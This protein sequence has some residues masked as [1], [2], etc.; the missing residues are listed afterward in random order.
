ME[1]LIGY[2]VDLTDGWH[3]VCAVAEPIASTTKYVAT[4]YVDGILQ[5]QAKIYSAGGFNPPTLY[6]SPKPQQVFEQLLSNIA[7]VTIGRHAQP[8]AA[9][10]YFMGVID[11]VKVFERALTPSEIR[12]LIPDSDDDFMPD[13][14]EKANNLDYLNPADAFFDPDLD[15]L[16]NRQEWFLRTDPHFADAAKGFKDSDGDGLPDTWEVMVGLNHLDAS[17]AYAD[18]DFDGVLNIYEFGLDTDPF[19]SDSDDNSVSD[20]SEDH[21]RDL[22]PDAWELAHGLN[23]REKDDQVDG[24][25][26]D[27]VNLVEYQRSSDPNDYYDGALPIITRISPD[28]VD[29]DPGAFGA[30]PFSVTI[31]KED[32]SLL[33]NAPVKFKVMSGDAKVAADGKDDPQLLQEID[34]VT[35]EMGVVTAFISYPSAEGDASIVRAIASTKVESAILDVTATTLS[36][37]ATPTATPAVPISSTQTITLQCATVDAVIYYT[38]S[39]IEPTSEDLFVPSGQTIQVDPGDILVIKASKVGSKDSLAN[40]IQY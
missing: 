2:G 36:M 38:L 28:L 30:E 16:S 4:L 35:D 23:I 1:Q 5:T 27:A 31:T 12:H 26:D 14:W 25:G 19:D 7:P 10:N 9:A 11:E 18:S 40:S 22:M 34:L 6:P 3:H 15:K 39:G 33:A 20:G 32:G 21:D 24:D 13:W 8:V 29:A 37:V 17:D